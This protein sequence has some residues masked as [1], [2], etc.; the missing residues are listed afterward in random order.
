MET[1]EKIRAIRQRIIQ[2]DTEGALRELLAWLE[3]AG[4]AP[5]RAWA[6]TVRSLK[7]RYRRTKNEKQKGV[8][9]YEQAQL[10]FNQIENALLNI[11]QGIENGDQPAKPSVTPSTSPKRAVPWL[12]IGVVTALVLAVVSVVLLRDILAADPAP[13]ELV[14][15]S[16]GE[17]PS[18]PQDS[19]FNI[20]VLPYKPLRGER[21]SIESSI[22]DRLA[23]SIEAYRVPAYV[24]TR[25]ID[26]TDAN[27]Y[28]SD[29]RSARRIGDPCAAQLV[30]W[31]TTERTPANQLIT[32]TSFRFLNKEHFNLADLTLNQNAEVDTLETISSIATEGILTKSIEMGI[33]LIFGLVAHETGQHAVAANLIQEACDS[34]GGVQENTKWG[35]VLA[36]S[37]VRSEQ[38]EKAI[39]TYDAILMSDHDN[40][41]ARTQRGYLT[42]E[43]G[44]YAAAEADFTEVLSR[45]STNGQVRV[46]RAAARIRT[47]RLYEAQQDLEQVESESGSELIPKGI[48]TEYLE[49][50]KS[51]EKSKVEAEQQLKFNPNDTTALRIQ[52]ETAQKL[53][54]FETASAA[55]SQLLVRDPNHINA[56]KTLLEVKPMLKDTEA[57]HQ[58][59]ERSRKEIPA[60]QMPVV[61]PLVP[62]R[63]RIRS[64]GR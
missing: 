64:G 12:T 49:R 47:D 32:T 53:G 18:Y 46:A 2:A 17:C 23:L 52:A 51:L 44:Q 62:P 3:D 54:D 58:L 57:V 43:L 28:P 60:T 33:Q 8:I 29:S 45:D 14:A 42:Y 63:Q 37:Y 41:T 61:R 22:K 39:A 6:D 5:L 13:D 24:M 26:V 9:A 50:Q 19:R 31:G 56:L 34:L 35:M 11:L 55:A 16:L 10:S 7:A 27:L 1:K 40:T 4:T 20:M 25:E 21:E 15:T 48:R 59:I 36:D 38:P 30:I